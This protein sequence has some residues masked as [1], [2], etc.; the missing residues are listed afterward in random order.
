[1]RITA[2]AALAL[3]STLAGS[4]A[5]HAQT[6][7]SGCTSIADVPPIY[8]GIQYGAAIL[9]IFTDYS[10]VGNGCADCH[11]SNG[12][13]TFP[14]GALDLDPGD[15]PSPYANLIG[16]ESPQHPGFVYVVPNHPEQSFLFMKVA[17]D[18][19]GGGQ[20]MPLGNYAGGLSVDQIALLYDWIAEGAPAGTTDGVFRG[21]FDI[22]G[23]TP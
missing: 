2:I 1:M 20:R 4:R 11:T 14:S 3:C 10:G 18:N 7:P 5:L 17:C 6:P 19:P 12:G 22:R 23:F 21:T 16:V 8:N 9:G 13:T 15:T